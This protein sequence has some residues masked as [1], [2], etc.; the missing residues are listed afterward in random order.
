VLVGDAGHHKDSIS[1]RGIGDAFLQADLLAGL[2]GEATGWPTRPGWTGRSR[3][4]P[5]SGTPGCS[6]GTSHAGDPPRRRRAGRCC[7]R[8]A[9][10]PGLTQRYFDTVAGVHPVA[11]LYT[12]DLLAL[13]NAQG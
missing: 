10:T 9:A 11:E 5:R 3:R 12:P 8:W 4:T 13:L 7:A 1:A 2:V 6:T